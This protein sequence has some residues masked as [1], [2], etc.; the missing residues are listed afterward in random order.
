M[1]NGK[2]KNIVFLTGA[3]ISAESGLSTFRD[4]DGLWNN[5]RVEDV[6]TAEAFVRQP[7]TV[8]SFYNE[9]KKDVLSARPNPAHL[10]IAK[11]QESP[12]YHVTVI[13]QNVDTLHEQAGSENVLH[14]HGRI[15]QA[16]C[17]NCGKISQALG[18]VTGKTP[19]PFCRKEGFLKPNI[20][21]FGENLLFL[22]EAQNALENCDIFVS[23]GTSG[24]VYPAAG[25]VR[26]AL[27]R[28]AETVEINK[29][30][31]A[32]SFLFQKRFY[33]PAGKIVPA[34]VRSLSEA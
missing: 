21:F 33:G 11:L 9:L 7:E 19:C 18:N 6:A 14:I 23:V 32:N 22:D 24:T 13:T 8:R 3:G 31:S 15:D 34:Y 26:E 2:T 27:L 5:H 17:L 1:E 12:L 4:S 29:E 10:A 16:V 20:V 25:F 30:E 28:G